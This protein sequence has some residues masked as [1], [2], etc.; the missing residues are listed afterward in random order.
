M[1]T[2]LNNNINYANKNQII[3]AFNDLRYRI[4]KR[5]LYSI[6]V[7]DFIKIFQSKYMLKFE[8]KLVSEVFEILFKKKL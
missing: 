6:S 1:S 7:E 8:K 5:C 3:I 2:E 4:S